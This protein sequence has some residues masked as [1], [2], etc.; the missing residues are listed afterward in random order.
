M[1][2]L[3]KSRTTLFVMTLINIFV[4]GNYV[5]CDKVL[6]GMGYFMFFYVSILAIY[7]LTKSKPPTNHI[8][9]REPKKELTVAV[10]F[11]LLGIVFLFMNFMIKESPIQPNGAIRIMVIIGSLTFSMPIGIFLYLIIKKYKILSLGFRIQPLSLL[12]IGVLIFGFTGLFAYVFNKEGIIWEEGYKELGGFFGLIMSGLIGAALFEEFSRFI[13]MSRFE[14]VFNVYGMNI[15]FA[16]VIW[17]FMHFPVTHF[18]G[19]E[20]FDNLIY[21]LQIIPIGFVWGYLTQRTH[22]I[23]PATLAHGFNLWGLQNG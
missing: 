3:K 11:A 7:L 13:L 18:K 12:L 15:L 10:I 16:T 6:H 9:V 22:S 17:A 23:L 4:L 19:A 1:E 5:S 8:L 2:E 21:C 14:K 20:L